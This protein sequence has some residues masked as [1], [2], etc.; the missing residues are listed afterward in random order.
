MTLANIY[1]FINLEYNLTLSDSNNNRVEIFNTL[2]SS[3]NI[4]DL[5]FPLNIYSNVMACIR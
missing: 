2:Y 3:I 1:Y 4:T 5:A